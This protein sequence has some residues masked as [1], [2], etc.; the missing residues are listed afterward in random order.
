MGFADNGAYTIPAGATDAI[1]GAVI[2]SAVWNSIHSDLQT[3]LTTVGQGCPFI[4]ANSAVV[5]SHTGNTTE[6]ALATIPIPAGALA[7]NGLLRITLLWGAT[8][9]ANN[10]TIRARLGGIGG[11]AFHT[12]IITTAI[13]VSSITNIGNRNSAA[14]Q[15]AHTIGI[16]GAFTTGTINTAVAQDLVISG[17]LATGS[18]TISLEA[19]VVEI[20]RRP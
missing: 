6:T 5:S 16:S 7:L 2:A 4:V 10:K 20:F 9:N 1:P 13:G 18:D 3:A 11:T 8:N 14:L 17:Q 19:R 15:V 12:Q